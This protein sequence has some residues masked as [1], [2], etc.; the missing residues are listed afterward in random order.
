MSDYDKSNIMQTDPNKDKQFKKKK[1]RT[2]IEAAKIVLESNPQTPMNCKTILQRIKDDNLKDISGSVP[3]ACLNS[4]LDTNSRGKDSV[5]YKVYGRA[6]V[7]GLKS[8]LPDGSEVISVKEEDEDIQITDSTFPDQ[9]KENLV[10]VKLPSGITTIPLKDEE[11]NEDDD[12][13]SEMDL[14]PQ[15][16]GENKNNTDTTNLRRSIR[17]SLRQKKKKLEYPRIIIKPIQPPPKEEKKDEPKEEII[18]DVADDIPQQNGNQNSEDSETDS[19]QSQRPQTMRE[20]LAGIPGFSMRPRKRTKKLSHA[21]QIAQTKEG[22]IDLET[23]DSILV[24]TN[25]RTLI[26]RHTFDLLPPNYQYKLLQLLPECD[27]CI[28]KDSG[29]RLSCTAFNNEFFAKA[30]QEWTQRL[31]DGELT[32]ENQGRLKQDEEREQSR[33]DPWKV[34]HFEPVYGKRRIKHEVPKADMPSPT[35][36]P[37]PIVSRKPQ[38]KK[39]TIVANMLKQRSIFQTVN[40]LK[41]NHDSPGGLLLKVVHKEHKSESHAVKRPVSPSIKQEDDIASVSP[42]KKAKTPPPV[43]TQSIGTY[44]HPIVITEVS[45]AISSKPQVSLLTSALTTS[46]TQPAIIKHTSLQASLSQ[47]PRTTSILHNIPIIRPPAQTRTLAQIKVTNAVRSQGTRTLAQIKAQTKARVQM[48][49]VQLSPQSDH[50]PIQS[51]P[52]RHIPNIMLGKKLSPINLVSKASN[53]PNIILA[54]KQSPVNKPALQPGSKTPVKSSDQEKEELT[55]DGIN[56]RRSMEIC[57]NT[58]VSGINIKRSMEICQSVIQ[59]TMAQF[60]SENPQLNAP[61]MCNM[62]LKS[63]SPV[64]LVP[65]ANHISAS[66]LLLTTSSNLQTSTSVVNTSASNKLISGAKDGGYVVSVTRV[67]STTVAPAS[68][69]TLPGT[70]TKFLIPAGNTTLTNQALMQLISSSQGLSTVSSSPARASSAPPINNVQIQNLVRSAS[71]GLNESSAPFQPKTSVTDTTSLNL[72]PEQLNF[73]SKSGT[74][75]TSG[76]KTP[77]ILIQRP[78]SAN[79]ITQSGDKQVT[80]IVVCSAAQL[81]Q[82]L[83]AKHNTVKV[84]SQSNQ[85]IKVVPNNGSKD[86]ACNLKAMIM[87]NKCGAFCHHDCIGS[88]RLC[89]NCV[90]TT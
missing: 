1:S 53:I 46:L 8:D 51:P 86:C 90:I 64:K 37:H 48:R 76:H 13:A 15:V 80:K 58:S 2:W 70:N 35:S 34:K 43:V 29:M 69:V 31:A 33:L 84:A 75:T 65:L 30:C 27:R 74:V 26:D 36:E 20:I 88:S 41:D 67:P 32:P 19:S 56:L 5:F 54:K 68:V 40:R 25:L 39:A 21:A 89:V 77:Q 82:Q 71:V 50:S 38:I 57:K 28:G 7:Y 24:T 45:E 9:K 73:L 12:D 62:N 10:Y 60:Q 17:Q 22:C 4:C 87:C 81:V 18:I 47:P 16:N 42:I 52:N 3:L 49:N 23:P 79:Q 11:E 61:E 59:K 63:Q 44:N 83:S 85:N 6:D 14:P 72:T 78:A 66:K 55:K